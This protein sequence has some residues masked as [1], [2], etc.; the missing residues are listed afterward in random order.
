MIL[1]GGILALISGLAGLAIGAVSCVGLLWPGTYYALVL[2][3]MGLIK[4]VHLMGEQAHKEAPPQ[5]I[6]IMM[7]INAINCDLINL[8]LGIL[9]LV[10]LGDPEVKDYFD[11]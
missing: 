4:G 10:F 3:I 7:I 2:G 11:R 1:I 8:T 9:V 5:G 6:A